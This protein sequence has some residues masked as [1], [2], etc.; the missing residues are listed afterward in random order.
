MEF[1][2]NTQLKDNNH[3]TFQRKRQPRKIVCLQTSKEQKQ[4]HRPHSTET[5]SGEEPLLEEKKKKEGSINHA[6]L[7]LT[8]TQRR[9]LTCRR[10]NDD[11]LVVFPLATAGVPPPPPI[12]CLVT[13]EKTES[14]SDKATGYR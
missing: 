3:V 13:G 4:L 8:T 6:T 9:R 2:P 7:T 1:R 12:R 14:L 5:P 10:N 11:R